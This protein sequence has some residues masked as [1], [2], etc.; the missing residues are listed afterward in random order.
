MTNIYKIS[1][2]RLINY[3]TEIEA[4]TEE[5]ALNIVKNEFDNKLFNGYE[6]RECNTTIEKY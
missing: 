1:I 3:E 4:E 5:E 2:Q 6:M